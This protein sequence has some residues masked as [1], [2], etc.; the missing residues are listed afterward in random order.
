[1][2]QKPWP[3]QMG[4]MAL[5]PEHICSMQSS[6]GYDWPLGQAASSYLTAPTMHYPTGH[7]TTLGRV[8]LHPT[9]VVGA[10]PHEGW[11]GAHHVMR[12]AR[13]LP[14]PHVGS[15][16]PHALMNAISSQALHRYRACHWTNKADPAEIDARCTATLASAQ[17]LTAA[18]LAL[19][20]QPDSNASLVAGIAASLA[21]LQEHLTSESTGTD[22]S[23]SAIE[24]LQ[25]QLDSVQEVIRE[26][27][28][29]DSS[30]VKD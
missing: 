7:R 15:G 2:A 4:S 13:H 10:H 26:R 27:G 11:R 1:M 12:R 8:G 30:C 25:A 14:Q 18:L 28:G 6:L 5:L 21:Q 24:Q 20:Q 17:R 9:R 22:D 23:L 29:P 16:G 19:L 3:V